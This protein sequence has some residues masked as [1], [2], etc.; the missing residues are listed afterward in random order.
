VAGVP[1]SEDGKV[2]DYDVRGDQRAD[3]ERNTA[4]VLVR[5]GR[6][7]LACAEQEKQSLGPGWYLR[8]DL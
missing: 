7:H 5:C 6:G 8:T 3:A 4:E 2:H 1:R